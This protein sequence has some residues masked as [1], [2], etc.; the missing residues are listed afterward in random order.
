MISFFRNFI[1]F[2][3]IL[4]IVFFCGFHLANYRM[5]KK[6]RLEQL[7]F[8]Q[9]VQQIEADNQ[10]RFKETSNEYDQRL[11]ENEKS[12]DIVISRLRSDFD[13]LQHDKRTAS[14]LPKKADTTTQHY[15]QKNPRFS[16]KDSEFLI[17]LAS[18]ADRNTEQLAACQKLL[19]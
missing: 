9:K 11:I 15:D 18:E 8:S 5:E 12:K 1:I 2:V 19:Q 14:I 3:I 4:V 13:R 7:K 6:I 10:K 16:L 17:Q